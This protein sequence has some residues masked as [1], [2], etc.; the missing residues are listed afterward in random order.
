MTIE[1]FTPE[2]EA[3]IVVDSD[4]LGAKALRIIA[5]LK[6]EVDVMYQTLDEQVSEQVEVETELFNLRVDLGKDIKVKYKERAI[7]A[8]AEVKRLRAETQKNANM[9][10]HLS[11]AYLGRAE[12]AESSLAAANALLERVRP[13][14]VGALVDAI[15]A[16]LAAQPSPTLSTFEQVWARKEAEGYQYGEDALQQVRFGFELARGT[17]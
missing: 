3:A 7:A 4:G 8:E 5:Q 6:S 17:K 15:D 1:K 9:F 2:E 16:H 14:W 10:E 11:D 13:H 12:R